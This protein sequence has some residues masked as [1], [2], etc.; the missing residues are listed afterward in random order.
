MRPS[1]GSSSGGAK[2]PLRTDVV[3]YITKHPHTPKLYSCPRTRMHAHHIGRD[4]SLVIT[5]VQ[6]FASLYCPY[7]SSTQQNTPCQG[8]K[9]PKHARRVSEKKSV[10][11]NQDPLVILRHTSWMMI[12]SRVSGNFGEPRGSR[13]K[14]STRLGGHPLFSSVFNAARRRHP[15]RRCF[16]IRRSLTKRVEL[17][18]MRCGRGSRQRCV[19][20]LQGIS[21]DGACLKSRIPNDKVH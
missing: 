19:Q 1:A 21:S 18:C 3:L 17:R 5:S 2:S 15:K 8:P 4:P 13:D 16:F 12:V 11:S 14:S 20:A 10:A 6:T 9:Q 7:C